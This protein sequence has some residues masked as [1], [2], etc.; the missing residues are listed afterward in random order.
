MEGTTRHTLATGLLVVTAAMLMLVMPVGPL[1]AQ[2]RPR[3]DRITP[4]PGAGKTVTQQGGASSIYGS[5]AVFNEKDSGEGSLRDAINY[6]NAHP[7]TRVLFPTDK[8]LVISPL[9]P[10]PP[11]TG[12]GTV[13]YGSSGTVAVPPPLFPDPFYRPQ[14]TG[15]LAW[16]IGD[17]AGKGA[18]GLVMQGNNCTVCGLVISDFDRYQITINGSGNKLQGCCCGVTPDSGTWDSR[19]PGNVGPY[20]PFGSFGGGDVAGG[21]VL[22]TRRH[23]RTI[24]RA[25]SGIRGS[26]VSTVY[27]DGNARN[28]VIGGPEGGAANFIVDDG[29]TNAN[30]RGGAGVHVAGRAANGTTIRNNIF[31]A[32]GPAIELEASSL[33][34][35]RITQVLPGVAVSVQGVLNGPPNTSFAVDLYSNGLPVGAANVT[36]D[37]AGI[38]SFKA[39]ASIPNRP[40][41]YIAAISTNLKTG[42]TSAFSPAQPPGGASI[43][44]R[45]LTNN[46]GH[47][48]PGIGGV[49]VT[50][51]LGEAL[52]SSTST[53]YPGDMNLGGN[54]NPTF[55]GYYQFCHMTPGTYTVAASRSDLFLLP[56]SRTVKLESGNATAIDFLGT[57]K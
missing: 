28:T 24:A 40:D 8:R 51:R 5:V 44:G 9:S 38:G 47:G 22:A 20:G 37:R 45:V 17:Q 54:Y 52:V 31:F 19:S 30:P 13:L 4:V 32:K 25:A 50:L 3:R 36:T 56:E 26:V 48:P 33:P 46:A 27:V 57:Q 11:I 34:A 6:A 43:F 15:P 18:D 7:G 49:P 39:V 14:Y 10:L 29:D 21:S 23:S 55:C 42:D 16:I 2:V 53:S 35:P 12:S 41:Q 1:H